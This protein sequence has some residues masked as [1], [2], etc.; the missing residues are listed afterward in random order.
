LTVEQ[1]RTIERSYRIGLSQGQIASIVGKSPA[2]VNRELARSFSAPG[3]RS[4][5]GRTARAGGQGYQRAYDAERS[6]RFANIKARRP[7]SRRLDHAPLRKQ[8]W[9]L[10]RADWSPQQIAATR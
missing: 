10:L 9:E 8:V 7:K 2:T 3:T 4:P 1:R 6:H 5:K